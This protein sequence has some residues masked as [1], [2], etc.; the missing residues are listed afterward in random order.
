ME[1]GFMATQ[2][3]ESHVFKIAMLSGIAGAS[4][5]LLFA[6]RSGI[7][8][9]NKLKQATGSMKHK[10][11]DTL[12]TAKHKVEERTRAAREAKDRTMHAMKVG[13]RSAQEEYQKLRNLNAEPVEDEPMPS[14]LRTNNQEGEV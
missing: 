10:A 7:E 8:T 6:P 13:K 4:L 2:H 5:A 3:M 9:R 12:D 11:E 1:G 14:D